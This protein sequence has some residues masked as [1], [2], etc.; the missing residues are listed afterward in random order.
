MLSFWGEKKCWRKEKGSCDHTSFCLLADWL[1]LFGFA[2]FVHGLGPLDAL[3]LYLLFYKFFVVEFVHFFIG[4]LKPLFLDSG[5]GLLVY[6]IFFPG[7]TAMGKSPGK[8]I[9]AVL[10]GKKSTKSNVS[11][12]REVVWSCKYTTMLHIWKLKCLFIQ[13]MDISYNQL[14]NPKTEK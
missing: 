4:T 10:F 12:G 9:K 5:S 1:V 6:A 11:K 3:L 2:I 7:L 8:W 14:A 13:A